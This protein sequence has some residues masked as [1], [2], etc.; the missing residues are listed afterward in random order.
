MQAFLRAEMERRGLTE[1]EARA[2]PPFGGPIYAN[3]IAVP[4]PCEAGQGIDH[5]GTVHW[6]GGPA[7]YVYVLEEGSDNP[8]VP[9]NLDMPEG[10]LWRL[11][12]L[13]SASAISSGLRYGTTPDVSFQALPETELAPELED[14][15][16]YHLVALLDVGLPLT[17]CLFTFGEPLSSG[18]PSDAGFADPSVCDDEGNTFGTACTEDSECSCSAAGY[19]ALMPGQSEGF[20][21]ATGCA[22]DMMCVPRLVVLRMSELVSGGIRSAWA[23]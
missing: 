18:N 16:T 4:K 13:A 14:G 19:C 8:G 2:V 12:A 6:I 7:R 20:C 10:T 15:A 1:E 3:R 11:D 21:T 17:S 23:P 9:P 5:D 22:E